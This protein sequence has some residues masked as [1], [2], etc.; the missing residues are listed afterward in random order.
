MPYEMPI[1]WMKMFPSR[2]VRRDSSESDAALKKIGERL[3]FSFSQSVTEPLP[4]KMQSLLV[5]LDQ[6]C[7]GDQDAGP[8]ALGFT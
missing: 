6:Q 5:E 4:H 8:P 2:E 7:D 1:E 3:Q